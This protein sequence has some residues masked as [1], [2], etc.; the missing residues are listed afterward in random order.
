MTTARLLPISTVAAALALAVG[1][2][3]SR[4]AGA[5]FVGALGLLWLLG[6]RRHAE[7]LASPMLA[8]FV[9][10]AVMGTWWDAPRALMLAGVVAALAAWDLDH[11]SQR[12]L[13][14][15]VAEDV[16]A[17][18]RGHIRRLLGVAGLG[19]LLGAIALASQVRLGLGQ[20][21]LLGL[22]A[23]VGLSGAVRFLRRESD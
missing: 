19:L 9:G 23:M 11:L 3:P 14:V 18:E 15:K 20:V 17:C 6:Q 21:F 5:V 10:A 4:W 8:V 12:L 2:G 13:S 1:Y 7:W 16:R 22:L